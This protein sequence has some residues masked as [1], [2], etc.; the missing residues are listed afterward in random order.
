MVDSE[1]FAAIATEFSDDTCPNTRPAAFVTVVGQCSLQP[2]NARLARGRLAEPHLLKSCTERSR[3]AVTCSPAFG[4]MAFDKQLDHVAH[5]RCV[6]P[7]SR[8]AHLSDRLPIV[9]SE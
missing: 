9:S 3:S 8:R 5:D 7:W 6:H 4:G 2:F 1:V